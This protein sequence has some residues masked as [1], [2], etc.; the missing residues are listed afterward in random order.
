MSIRARAEN[1]P[2]R[3]KIIASFTLILM[4]LGAVGATA[5]VGLGAMDD[6]VISISGNSSLGLI[7]LNNMR[8]S[9]EAYKGATVSDVLAGADIAA[10]SL[11]EA[12][13]DLASKSFHD[14][15]K[16]YQPTADPGQ[17][18]TIYQEITAATGA[19]FAGASHVIALLHDGKAAEARA[20][21][22][23]ELTQPAAKAAIA[24]QQDIDYNTGTFT[25]QGVDSAAAYSKTRLYVTA[26]LVAS[27]LTALIAGTFLV[28]SIARPIV[29][30]TSAMRRLAAN[31]LTLDIPAL[32]R[33]DEIGQMA[34]AVQTFKD[35]LIASEQ[36]SAGQTSERASKEQRN[37]NLECAVADFERVSRAMAEQLSSGSADLET[38]ARSMTGTADQT[39]EQA[40]AVAAAAQEAGSGAQT[41]AAAAEQLTASVH[42]I[43]RQVVQS[44]G[45][46]ARA[47]GDA[48]RTNTIVVAL[49]ES[50]NKIGNVVS[51]ITTIASQT[52]LLALNATIEAARA[53]DAGKGFAVVAAEVKSLAGQT[54]SATEEIS[55]QIS[56]IQ[57]ATSEAVAAIRSISATIDEISS[58]T[59]SV[60]SAVEQQGVAT[61]EIARSVQQT[62]SA[63]NE[64][65]NNIS[66][67][68]EA[69]Q[70]GSNA[71]T[72]VLGAAADLSK[73]ARLLSSQVDSFV[74]AVRAA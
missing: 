46:A 48:Q 62:A 68:T 17:E 60:A 29:T 13:L 63:V 66:G 7:S 11:A 52:N 40:N 49:A 14:A 35:A 3:A 59:T 67:V 47:V 27:V 51:L 43:S 41:V 57:S 42:E 69:A 15:D 16:I 36:V 22:A 44:A 54:A 24:F 4:L 55:T 38:T 32:N 8:G 56:Q 2:I 64:V 31:D 73:Q 28:T 61:S 20:A 10:R 58:I 34:V 72:R 37:K 70:E 19:Y 65:T 71:A 30:M 33:Q 9:F 23:A 53:G 5:M 26:L 21:L 12:S 45:T 1:L 74:S 39:N 50:A 25:Q 6:A 18:T